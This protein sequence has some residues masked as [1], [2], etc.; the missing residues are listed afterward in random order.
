ML[1]RNRCVNKVSC[2]F[3]KIFCVPDAYSTLSIKRLV[4]LNDL[5]WIF[6]KISIKRPG[7]SQK[8]SIL[9]FY[10]RAAMVNFWALLI[11]L[12]S[13]KRLFFNSRSLERP[14]LLIEY[15]LTN[16]DWFFST[17]FVICFDLDLLH[18][19]FVIFQGS[20]ISNQL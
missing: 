6:P 4:L 3:C 20:K 14:G 13:I 16:P 17:K 15:V 19:I 10:F 9:L 7:P 8:K 18:Q 2:M 12:V 5:I 11:N 1:N